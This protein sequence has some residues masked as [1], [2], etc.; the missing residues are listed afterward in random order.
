[1]N[2]LVVS[3][4]H[5]F[6]SAE[7]KQ[8]YLRAYD[9]LAAKWPS[10]SETRV[11]DTSFGRT[12]TRVQG[13][14]DGEPLF[15][16]PGDTETSL[17]WLPV[18]EPLS[19]TYRTYAVDHVYDNG[20]SVYTKGMSCPT[21]FVD[22]L[23]EVFDGLGLD[24]LTLVGYSYGAWQSALCALAH[25][26]RIQRLVLLAPSATVLSPG[27]TMLVRVVLYHF[28]PCRFIAKNY[29]YWYGPDAI[30]NSR[31]RTQVD[32]M[33]DEDLLARRCF[34]KR[35]FVPPTRLTDAEWRELRVPTLFLIGENDKTYSPERA[36]LRLREIAPT[37]A[38]KIAQ[39]TDHYI[40]LVNPD[41]VVRHILHFLQDAETP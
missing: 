27:P 30:K 26:D 8:E 37:V 32:A 20:R 39:K 22:W 31:T 5:P 28:L 11:I 13:P 14:V 33:I 15:L 4:T 10:A 19:Q 17:S 6:R 2:V 41:W 25:P 16:L 12:F 24:R 23:N 9:K 34:K 3:A 18:I 38:A 40:T 29:F 35:K 21:D 36:V 7:A 1:M